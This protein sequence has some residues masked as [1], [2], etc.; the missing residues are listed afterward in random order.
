LYDLKKKN[1][2]VQNK[3]VDA[4]GRII[5]HY[6]DVPDVLKQLSGE[7][8]ELGVASRTSEIKGARQLIDL[9]GWKK[10]FKYVEIFPGSKI[11]HFSK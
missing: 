6:S 8:Y 5:R 9:F 7:G 11:T 1:F 2:R 3:V 10:Y 4:H